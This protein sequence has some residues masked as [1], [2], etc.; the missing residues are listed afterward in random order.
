[1]HNLLLIPFLADPALTAIFPDFGAFD[2]L[3]SE[4]AGKNDFTHVWSHRIVGQQIIRD[5]VNTQKHEGH[6]TWSLVK[7]LLLF[8]SFNLNTLPDPIDFESI[9]K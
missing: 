1:V 6:L 3:L 9:M 5:F 4:L 2:L 7:L 8:M